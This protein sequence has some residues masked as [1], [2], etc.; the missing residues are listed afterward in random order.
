MEKNFGELFS[1][2]KRAFELGDLAQTEKLVRAALSCASIPIEHAACHNFLGA[3]YKI[4]NKLIEATT[5]YNLA[6][7]IFIRYRGT[8]QIRAR[9]LN[10]LG[11]IYHQRGMLPESAVAFQRARDLTGNDSE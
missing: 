1:E 6:L 8:E 4:Q 5:A 9:C 11:S 7:A 2:A 3:I 10:A